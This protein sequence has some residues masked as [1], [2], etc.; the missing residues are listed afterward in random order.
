MA[1]RPAAAGQNPTRNGRARRSKPAR[2]RRARRSPP[3]GA[4]FPPALDPDAPGRRR[5]RAAGAPSCSPPICARRARRSIRALHPAARAFSDAGRSRRLAGADLRAAARSRGARRSPQGSLAAMMERRYEA[6]KSHVVRPFFRDH[7]AR[8]DRQIVLVD[9]L[10][11]LNSGPAACA[12]SKRALTEVLDRL[13]HRA[14]QRCCRRCSGRKS[15][16]SCSPRPRPTICTTSATTGW[17]R[18]CGNLTAR[19]I[20]ARRGVRRRGRCDRAGRRARDPRGRG[21]AAARETLDAI[22]GTPLAG[23]SSTARFSTARP[24]RRSF[25]A[26]CRPTRARSFAATALAHAGGRS[27]LPL[28]ALPPAGRRFGADGKPLPLPHIR[29]DR[30]CQF[31]FGDRLS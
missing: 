12:I 1:A 10:A 5:R 14:R 11:A 23:E 15:T 28:P 26:N 21:A 29:L 25:P 7:F 16:R 8:L 18:S 22:V 31:L 30:A 24:R 4:A 2:R 9:A 6:Y 20:A 17:R 3:N 19:A 13:P 27:R